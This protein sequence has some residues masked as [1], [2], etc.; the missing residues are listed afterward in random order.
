MLIE[1]ILHP[2]SVLNLRGD[3]DFRKVI[4]LCLENVTY[5]V[6][7]DG[8]YGFLFTPGFGEMLPKLF[9]HWISADQ[10]FFTVMMS[11]LKLFVDSGAEVFRVSDGLMQAFGETKG[12]V[13]TNM[14]KKE[15]SIYVSFSE[16]YLSYGGV[17]LNGAYINCLK[18]TTGWHYCIFVTCN[19]DIVPSSFINGKIL[20]G[21]IEETI[22]EVFSKYEKTDQSEAERAEW[23]KI[24]KVCF[25]VLVYL[26]SVDPEILALKPEIQ[27][28]KAEKAQSKKAEHRNR[29]MIPVELLSWS[30]HGHDTINYTKDEWGRVGHFRWQP[31]GE[32]LSQVKLIWLAPQVCKR[33]IGKEGE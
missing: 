21:S 2:E 9:G 23:L 14:L 15:K 24:L 6:C 30:Y 19:R 8:R 33:Q 29:C 31:Y 1:K 26:E 3:K 5:K 16:K 11:T 4:G 18:A 28:S 22:E 17:P 20:D 10:N 12:T 27:M 32:G 25:N 13:K 7:E